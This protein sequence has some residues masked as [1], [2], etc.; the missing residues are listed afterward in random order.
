MVAALFSVYVGGLLVSFAVSLG[1]G[2]L[3]V[4]LNDLLAADADSA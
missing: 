1:V 2:V 3:F 4:Y